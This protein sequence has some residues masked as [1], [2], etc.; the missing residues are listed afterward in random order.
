MTGVVTAVD[1]SG[2][3]DAAGT[4]VA[5]ARAAAPVTASM[6]A[7]RVLN[8]DVRFMTEPYGLAGMPVDLTPR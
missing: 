8:A 1:G 3:A 7:S 6:L 5:Q 2:W 4:V